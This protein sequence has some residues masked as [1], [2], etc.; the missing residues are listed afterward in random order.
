MML[1]AVKSQAQQAGTK[2]TNQEPEIDGNKAIMRQT[3]ETANWIDDKIFYLP[4]NYDFR[5]VFIRCATLAT[6]ATIIGK[7]Y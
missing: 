2:D 5:V 6:T 3:L 4:H 1:P 7:P